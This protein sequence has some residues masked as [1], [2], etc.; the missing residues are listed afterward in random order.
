[1]SVSGQFSLSLQFSD[2]TTATNLSSL[3]S[4]ALAEET[5]YSTGKVA[6]VSGTIGT[7]SVS[8]WGGSAVSLNGQTYRNAAGN[9]VS[10]SLVSR[11]WFQNASSQA[12]ILADE[13]LQLWSLLSKNNEVMVSGNNGGTSIGARALSGTASVTVVLYGS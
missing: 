5:D 2:S 11:V 13:D 6:I 4:I 10:L 7:S 8:V 1:V 12:A 9:E 3:K